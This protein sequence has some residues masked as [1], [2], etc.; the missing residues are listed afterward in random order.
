MYSIF[1]PGHSRATTKEKRNIRQNETSNDFKGDVMQDKELKTFGLYFG[2]ANGFN[3]CENQKVMQADY[4]RIA[5]TCVDTDKYNV[6]PTLHQVAE[7]TFKAYS[8]DLA[9]S[10]IEAARDYQ[11][12]GVM[13]IIQANTV[14]HIKERGS[15]NLG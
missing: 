7:S 5:K 3:L 13:L 12:G 11:P 2:N 9:S 14:G 10:P 8:M 6:K 4:G 15:N 1:N